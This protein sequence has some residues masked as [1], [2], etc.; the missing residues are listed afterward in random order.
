MVQIRIGAGGDP[1]EMAFAQHSHGQRC[2]W[3]Q[4]QKRGPRPIV[5]VARGSQAS[6]ASA[7]RHDAPVVPDHADGKGL[8]V[9]DATLDL[10]DLRTPRWVAW[11]GRWG[12]TK[13]RHR[14]ESNSPRGPAHQEKWRDPQVF[15]DECDE[16]RAE[17]APP[18]LPPGPA[19][20]EISVRREGDRAFVIY[21]FT[22]TVAGHPPEQ[23]LVTLDSLGDRLPPATQ[24]FPVEAQSGELEHPLPLDEGRYRV[25]VSA[26]D[27][28]GN[29]SDPAT[30][31]LDELG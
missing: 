2:R 16:I 12:S 9:A 25:L 19:P 10:I 4:V 18:V 6:F 22:Q 5:Y 15:H 21:R 1:L 8:E 23:L 26:A 7:G 27:A 20:P 28:Q 24:A 31:V 3:A 29:V 11:Q 14:L 30:A 13:A 17:R